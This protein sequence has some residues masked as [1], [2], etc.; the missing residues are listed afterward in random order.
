MVVP[1]T[2]V[3]T[4]QVE[5]VKFT[6]RPDFNPTLTFHALGTI[7]YTEDDDGHTEGVVVSMEVIDWDTIGSC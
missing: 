7:E 5:N 3:K 6:Y 4:W 2:A 1:G